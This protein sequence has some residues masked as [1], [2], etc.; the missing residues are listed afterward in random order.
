MSITF[1][2]GSK[3]F[4]HPCDDSDKLRGFNVQGFWVDQGDIHVWGEIQVNE[5]KK[6]KERAD[7]IRK[8]EASTMI[9]D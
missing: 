4:L 2:N 8:D 9:S 3:I 6:L 5:F 1:S 7:V